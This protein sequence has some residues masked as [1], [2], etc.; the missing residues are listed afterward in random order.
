[1]TRTPCAHEKDVFG[2]RP[3]LVL[4]AAVLLIA[5]VTVVVYSPAL[6]A[7]F[8]NWDDD[9]NVSENPGFRPVTARS[10]A[11]FWHEPFQYMYI[12]LTYTVW[13]LTAQLCGGAGV[14]GLSPAPFH[15]LNIV[16][17]VLSALVVFSASRLVLNA[18]EKHGTA[19]TNGSRERCVRYRLAA[20]A[21]AALLFALHPVQAEAVCWVTGAKDVLCGL[22]CLVAVWHYLAA[23][24]RSV[25][26]RMK[27]YVL[28]TV[29]CALALLSKP[30]AAVLPLLA[31]ATAALALERG[32]GRRGRAQSLHWILILWLAAGICC[33]LYAAGL[34]PAAHRSTAPPPV[35][36]RPLVALD[37]V[38]FYV[39][40]LVVPL[41]FCADY[42]RTPQVVLTHPM[43]W[44][45]GLL[46]GVFLA[47]FAVKG[48]RTLAAAGV[49]VFVIGVLPVAGLVPFGFQEFSTVADRYLYVSMLGPALAL[50]GLMSRQRQRR[51]WVVCAAVLL[52]LGLRTAFQA[53]H[54]LDSLSLFRHTLAVNAHSYAGHSNLGN[55]LL[56]DSRV[57]EAVLHLSKALEIR[58]RLADSYYNLGVAKGKAG[59][60]EEAVRLYSRALQIRTGYADAHNNLGVALYDM[61]RMEEAARHLSAALRLKPDLAATQVVLGHA[62]FRQGLPAQ[63]AEHYSRALVLAPADAATRSVL[64]GV[65][66]K[67]GS[68][69]AALAHYSQA[70]VIT[71][72]D[73][74]LHYN[75]AVALAARGRSAQAIAHY[76]AAIRLAPRNFR[77]LHNLGRLLAENGR[78]EEAVTCYSRALLVKPD[79][80]RAHTQL[81][82]AL[83]GLGRLDAAAR[84]FSAALDLAPDSE[85]VRRALQDVRTAKETRE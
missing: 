25:G 17:H 33:T 45:A 48:R 6:R 62:L 9:I 76:S 77:A 56:D 10:V 20:S 4:W 16:L 36:A 29:C 42:G 50:A 46:V 85:D 13:A 84:H 30:A 32:T 19:D 79:Y 24:C 37:A 52:L 82:N 58:P 59:N 3:T 78:L 66:F 5:G 49:A 70:L 12:P 21:A 81:G 39:Y 64:G 47:W 57:D 41:S 73:A 28:A 38:A 68:I 8:V 71:P 15:R 27:H 55:A 11:R 69:E 31:A 43:M 72:D 54:W 65:L 63:A 18:R 26:S 2:G 53:R 23:R 51:A 61:G 40:K 1:M 34:Q 75:L 35:V 22:L 74:A 67:L 7:G 80:L 14:T 60:P 83:A 44:A